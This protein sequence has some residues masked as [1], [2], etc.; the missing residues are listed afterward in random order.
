MT[1]EKQNRT[2]SEVC[3]ITIMFP[4]DSDEKAVE[5]KAKIK[6]VVSDIENV[7]FDFR[8]TALPMR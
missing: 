3:S 4:V 2:G 7:R 1:N 5:T 8:I 6:E